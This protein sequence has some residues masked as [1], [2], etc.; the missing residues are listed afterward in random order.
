MLKRYILLPISFLTVL[1]IALLP[2]QYVVYPDYGPNP[3]ALKSMTQWQADGYRHF[4]QYIDSANIGFLAHIILGSI[5]LLAGFPQF[6]SSFRKNHIQ[7][8]KRLGYTYS[9][10]VMVCGFA[11][12]F[13]ATQARGGKFAQT[14]FLLLALLWLF[15]LSKALKRLKQKQFKL[16]GRWMGANYALTLA[17]VSLR[18]EMGI[19]T[20]LGIDGELGYQIVAWSS[21]VG[22][23]LILIGWRWHKGDLNRAY[24][25]EEPT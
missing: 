11:G 21:W 16:H 5:C 1:A 22:N 12:L 9:F 2:L 17:A 20:V 23:I 3:D 19:Y 10:A 24:L 8:H 13:L 14:G 6:F 7:W 4:Y 25:L 18:L 15:T